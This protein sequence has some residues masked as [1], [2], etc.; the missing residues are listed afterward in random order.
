MPKIH[1]G[2][3]KRG[4]Y[5]Y[6]FAKVYR[7]NGSVFYLGKRSDSKKPLFSCMFQTKSELMAH[8]PSIAGEIKKLKFEP[9]K[10]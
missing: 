8:Y 10:R 4:K 6:E 1:S 3:I 2:K 9:V 5:T 7:D